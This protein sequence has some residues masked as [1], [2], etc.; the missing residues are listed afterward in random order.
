MDMFAFLFGHLF[1]FCLTVLDD[2]D[3]RLESGSVSL[4]RDRKNACYQLVMC[5]LHAIEI[6]HATSGVRVSYMR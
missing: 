3:Q 1:V 2:V 6:M 4:T 5:R